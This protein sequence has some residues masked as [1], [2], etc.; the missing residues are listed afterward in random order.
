M[1][2]QAHL[3]EE[4]VKSFHE[5]VEIFLLF[6]IDGANYI[7]LEDPAWDV[8]YVYDLSSHFLDLFRYSKTENNKQVKY[9]LLGFSTVYTHYAYPDRKRMRIRYFFSSKWLVSQ[10]LILPPYQKSGH[11]GNS[12]SLTFNSKHTYLNL[13]I[14]LHTILTQKMSQ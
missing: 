7:D 8:Y 4:E 10:V 6:F 12:S 13:S 2:L 1:K 3:C 11:G 5:K 9:S 14:K